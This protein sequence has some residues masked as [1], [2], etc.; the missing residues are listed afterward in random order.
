MSKKDIFYSCFKIIKYK[1]TKTVAP[2][3][4]ISQIPAD[5]LKVRKPRTPITIAAENLK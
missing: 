5:V 3:E 4:N 1:N 2:K